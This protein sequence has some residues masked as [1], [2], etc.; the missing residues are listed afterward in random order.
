MPFGKILTKKIFVAM[1]A[2]T[3]WMSNQLIDQTDDN[4]DNSSSLHDEN[5]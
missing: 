4:S 3:N 5:T 1:R 2:K